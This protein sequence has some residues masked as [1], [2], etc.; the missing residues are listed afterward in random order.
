[1]AHR[2]MSYKGEVMRGQ[3]IPASLFAPIAVL[4]VGLGLWVAPGAPSEH[5]LTSPM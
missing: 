1:M 3:T 5:G 4:P 2:D